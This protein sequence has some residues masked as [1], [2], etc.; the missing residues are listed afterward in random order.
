MLI[1]LVEYKQFCGTQQIKNTVGPENNEKQC[2]VCECTDLYEATC[3][4]QNN[5]HNI[6]H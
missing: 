6:I 3:Y 2:S 1:V 5:S 4:E